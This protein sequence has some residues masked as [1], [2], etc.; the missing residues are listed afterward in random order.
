MKFIWASLAMLLISSVLGLGIGLA[1][2]GHGVWLL[3]LSI[4]G[5]LAMFIAYGCRSH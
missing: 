2:H 1:A 3:I 4:I 5:F